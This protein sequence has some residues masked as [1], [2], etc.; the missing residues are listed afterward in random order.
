MFCELEFVEQLKFSYKKTKTQEKKRPLIG[1]EVSPWS[2]KE[3][4]RLSHRK[5]SNRTL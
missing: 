2:I 3:L 5:E 1:G 4:L